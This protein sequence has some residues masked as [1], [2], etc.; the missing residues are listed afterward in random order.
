MRKQITMDTC[1]DFLAARQPL[2]QIAKNHL[3]LAQFS[4]YLRLVVDFC[5]H[6]HRVLDP[7]QAALPQTAHTHR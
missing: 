2:W 4:R 5:Y 1:W 7:T 3:L 6:M